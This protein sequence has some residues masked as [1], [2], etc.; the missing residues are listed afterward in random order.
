MHE[1]TNHQ[2]PA[3]YRHLEL[4][5]SYNT[6][7]LQLSASFLLA[8]KSNLGGQRTGKNIWGLVVASHVLGGTSNAKP[9]LLSTKKYKKC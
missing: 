8:T 1:N 4:G 2:Q 6:S 3:K 5:A 9:S 7:G